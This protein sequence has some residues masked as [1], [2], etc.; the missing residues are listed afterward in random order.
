[1]SQKMAVVEVVPPPASRLVGEDIDEEDDMDRAMISPLVRATIAMAVYG[2]K[3]ASLSG[4]G[5]PRPPLCHITG[6]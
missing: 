2:Y 6:G 1:M 5:K 4:K 3:G